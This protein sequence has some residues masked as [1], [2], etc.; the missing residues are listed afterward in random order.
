MLLIILK[1]KMKKSIVILILLLLITSLSSCGDTEQS[2]KPQQELPSVAVQG[3][4]KGKD[5]TYEYV[6]YKNFDDG[7]GVGL[8]KW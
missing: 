8:T 7:G 4:L 3:T 5:H 1:L 2:K 6:D